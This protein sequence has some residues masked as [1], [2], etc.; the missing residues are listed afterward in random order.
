MVRDGARAPPH[1]EGQNLPLRPLIEHPSCRPEPHPEE[2]RLLCFSW[3]GAPP[4]LPSFATAHGRVLMVRD[5]ARAPPHHEGQ[6][7]PLRPLIEHPS[8]SPEPH[9]ESL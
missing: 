2:R 9:P 6:N 4:G 7:L 3:Y 1:H 8:C 5:G